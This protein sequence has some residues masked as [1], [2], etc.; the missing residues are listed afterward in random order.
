MEKKG[1]EA[2]RF[3]VFAQR[4]AS[5]GPRW[6]RARWGHPEPLFQWAVVGRG[7]HDGNR[8]IAP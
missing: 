8:Q 3:S 2:R 6:T 7:A 5:E 4:A 1:K